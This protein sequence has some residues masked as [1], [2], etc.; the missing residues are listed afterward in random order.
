MEPIIKDPN[1]EIVANGVKPDS[2]KR[3]VLSKAQIPDN[4]TYHVYRN[5]IGQIILDPQITI[6]AS[7]LWLFQNKEALA[8]VHKGLLESIHGDTTSLGSF[9]EFVKDAP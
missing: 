8:S 4:V 2:K 5:A 6:P 9:A 7:E 1:F 3:V